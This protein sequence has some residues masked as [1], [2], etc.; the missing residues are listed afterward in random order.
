MLDISIS[1]Q[2][3]RASREQWKANG[4]EKPGEVQNNEPESE[5]KNGLCVRIGLLHPSFIYKITCNENL[6][7]KLAV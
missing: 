2:V 1:L 4:S 7:W 6:I 3:C 5:G